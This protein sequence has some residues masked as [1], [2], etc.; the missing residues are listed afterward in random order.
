[1]IL[2]WLLGVSQ[3]SQSQDMEKLPITVYLE[4]KATMSPM[5][6]VPLR[7]LFSANVG[8]K[9]SIS[10]ITVYQKRSFQARHSQCSTAK[11]TDLHTC[12]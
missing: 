1:M 6:S 7:P 5:I 9:Y 2:Q 4:H 12:R 8:F 10:S 3:S 11:I